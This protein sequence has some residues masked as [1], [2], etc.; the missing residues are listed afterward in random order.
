MPKH[1]PQ[2]PVTPKYL[3]FE[4][5]AIYSGVGERLLRDATKETSENPLPFYRVN[6]KTRLIAQDDLDAWMLRFRTEPGDHV[7]ALV[8][9]VLADLARPAPKRGAK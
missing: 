4:Q 9:G 2:C 6:S 7:A 1:K 8:D 5:A 3:T